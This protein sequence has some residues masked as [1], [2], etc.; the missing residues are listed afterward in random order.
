[1]NYGQPHGVLLFFGKG[2]QWTSER[3]IICLDAQQAFYLR[4]QQEGK[5][6]NIGRQIHEAGLFVS[7]SITSDAELCTIL[8]GDPAIR[9]EV[10]Q[11]IQAVPVIF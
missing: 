1:M 10:V 5:V 3:R 8:D 9:E 11:V 2:M 7:L 6:T 4:L